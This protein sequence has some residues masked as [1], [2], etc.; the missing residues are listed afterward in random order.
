M[1]KWIGILIICSAITAFVV[2]SFNWKVGPTTKASFVIGGPLGINVKGTIDV[3]KVDIDFNPD[4]IIK[5]SLY[6]KMIVNTINTNNG[7]RDKHLKTADYFDATTYPE[8]VFKSTLITKQAS[9]KF[10]ATGN[11]SIKQIT[12]KIEIPFTFKQQNN[13]ATFQGSFTIKRVDYGIGNKSMM[14]GN[15]VII[16]LNIFATK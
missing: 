4:D 8:I 12:K 3:A 11:L 5:S 7:S 2:D 10:I 13:T 6:A 1:K 15:E 14:M 16:N 9:G